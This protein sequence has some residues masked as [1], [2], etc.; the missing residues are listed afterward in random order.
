M[1]HKVTI[2]R[3]KN[4][5]GPYTPNPSNPILTHINQQAQSNPIQGTGHADLVQA[6]DGSWW[7][8]CLGFRTQSGMHHLLGRETFLAKVTWENDWPVVNPGVGILTETVEIDLFDDDG[9]KVEKAKENGY[10]E[11]V[12]AR[13]RYLPELSSSNAMMRAFGERVALN[14]PI[15]G[16]A[17]D[18][19]KIAMVRVYRRLQEEG[20]QARLILQVHDELLLECP[21]EEVETAARIRDQLKAL[22]QKE[23]EA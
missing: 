4:I 1:G 7:M 10:V 8:V 21:P 18:I 13:R 11:T 22:A 23:G 2:A 9:E 6:Q 5:D 12:F 17:A 14:M 19:I 20:L 3:S 16:T 15:Q